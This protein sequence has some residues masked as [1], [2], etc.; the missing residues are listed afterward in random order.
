MN[1]TLQHGGRTAVW[2]LEGK[3]T[4]GQV[5]QCRK[6]WNDWVQENPAVNLIVLDMHALDFIDSAGMGLLVSILKKMSSVGGDVVLA[7]VPAPVRIL[8]EVTRL[9]RV[10][11]VFT[12]VDAALADV[13]S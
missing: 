11:R 7:A 6:S 10:F 4:T 3:L 2:A 5:S 1:T 9:H 12:D 13:P 8:F